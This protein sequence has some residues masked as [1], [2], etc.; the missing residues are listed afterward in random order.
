MAMAHQSV[1]PSFPMTPSA[2]RRSVM[3]RYAAAA[4]ANLALAGCVAA[5]LG[6]AGTIASPLVAMAVFA[7]AAVWA[8]AAMARTYPHSV[9]GLANLVT[10][11]RLALAASLVAT[12]THPEGLTRSDAQAWAVL[13][14][15]IL[16]LCLDGVDGRLARRQR[17]TSAFGARFDM[18]V[19]AF[20]AALLAVILVL[21]GKVGLWA[22]PLGFMRYG[23]VIA[24][25]M[26]PWMRAPLPD[27]FGRKAVCVLQIG[28][29]VALLAPVIGPQ[30][31]W[32][33]AALAS[34]ALIR[35]F[36]IDIAWLWRNRP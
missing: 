9:L 6:P 27:R 1:A 17:L 24:A 23:F 7:I 16:A 35:S 2:P 30:I 36:A 29:L 34:A 18:E 22:L 33:P 15:A 14:I 3:T 19:D 31:A 11:S 25:A 8:G 28:T 10:L 20:F 32:A 4:A 26:L 5:T 13:G 21:S 12:L